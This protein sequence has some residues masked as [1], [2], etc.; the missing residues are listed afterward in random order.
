LSLFKQGWFD[1]ASARQSMGHT[2][3][4]SKL[5]DHKVHSAST[6]VIVSEVHTENLS[7]MEYDLSASAVQTRITLLFFIS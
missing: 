7:G 3:I 1:L 2:R 4:S 6:T 5:F